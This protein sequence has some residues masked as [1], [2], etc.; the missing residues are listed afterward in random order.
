MQQLEIILKHIIEQLFQQSVE[1]TLTRPKA[2]F[3]DFATNIAL[4]LAGQL[5][6]NPRQIAE[7]I[8]QALAKETSDFSAEIAGPGFIN[9]KIND[10]LLIKSLQK[11]PNLPYKDQVVLVEYSDPNAFKVLHAGHFYTSVVGDAIANLVEVGGGQVKRLNFGGDVGLHVG[12]TLWAVIKELG[13]EHPQKLAEIK[14]SQRADWLAKCYVAGTQAYE[15]NDQAHRQITQYNSAVYQIHQDNDH[16]SPLAQIYWTTREWSYNYFKDFYAKIGTHFD[17]FYPESS[18]ADRGL[19]EVKQ[20][21]GPVFE[22]SNQAIVFNGEKYGLHTRVF[23]NQQ[24]LPTYE[25]KDIGL[26]FTKYDDWHF[27]KSIIITA[28][29]QKQYMEV[30]LKALEQFAPKLANSTLHITHGIVKLA[31]GVKMSSRKGNFLRAIDVFDYA[32][33]A[34]QKQNGAANQDT[35]LGAIKY[36]FLKSRIGGDI[37]YDPQESVSLTGNSGPYLQYAYA[38]A[39]SIIAKADQQIID[40]AEL[41]DLDPAERKLV[42]KMSEWTEVLNQATAELLPHLICTYLYQLAAEFNRFYEK[43]QII[44]SQRQAL[45]LSLVNH[46]SQ[47][48]KQGLQ[49]LGIKA[50]ERI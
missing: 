26:V 4:Q 39:H 18:V 2:E 36:A 17:K 27:D 15:D 34:N 12:K 40:L 43:S 22:Q 45:R 3:G 48:L 14:P 35:A 23:I 32:M 44:G 50:I 30:V 10:K 5:Q 41:T 11:Q 13:G 24:G 42:I 7:Q 19:A 28:D 6:Q 8:V 16:D 37:V 33:A 21:I 25:T 9:F 31:G 46:Y 1:I 49:I 29:E 20:Q 47:I 38:R